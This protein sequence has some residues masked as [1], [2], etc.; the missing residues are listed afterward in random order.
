MPCNL[1]DMEESFEG[2]CYLQRQ[3]TFRIEAAD[4]SEML[5]HIHQ[6]IR[7]HI[8]EE[9]IHLSQSSENLTSHV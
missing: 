7:R 4:S 1:I 2:N 9:N 3:G 6:T 8:Q 5:I